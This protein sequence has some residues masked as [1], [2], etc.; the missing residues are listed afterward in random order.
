[1]PYGVVGGRKINEDQSEFLLTLKR[2]FNVVDEARDLVG[3]RSALPKPS[4]NMWEMELDDVVYSRQDYPFHQFI[5]H[6]EKGDGPIALWIV[7]RLTRLEDGS[8][9]RL[10][11]DCRKGCLVH[12]VRQER[13][14]PF[15]GLETDGFHQLRVNMVNTRCLAVPEAEYSV[16]D[17]LS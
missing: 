6:A 12:A 3:C 1:M 14:K 15:H 8:D 17:F 16:D 5:R 4:L 2:R 10:P 11:P 13:S 9:L 7:G